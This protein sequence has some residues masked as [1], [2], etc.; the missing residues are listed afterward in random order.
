VVWGGAISDK[1]CLVY[2]VMIVYKSWCGLLL[3]HDSATAC[4]MVKIKDE[5]GEASECEK[6]EKC[7]YCHSRM[8]LQFHPDVSRLHLLFLLLQGGSKENVPPDRM[9]FLDK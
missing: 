2:T 7:T 1:T 5:W 3:L 6:G 9:Q 4:P 8:E